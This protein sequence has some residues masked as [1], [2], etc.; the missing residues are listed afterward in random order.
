MNNKI[1]RS[2]SI[3]CTDNE[4]KTICTSNFQRPILS[5]L[6]ETDDHQ[7]QS[8]L[9]Y[10]QRQHKQPQH[11]AYNQIPLSEHQHQPHQV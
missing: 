9:N 11:C 7:Q 5:C 2:S 8:H 10:Q 1:V 4:H 6:N 3:G